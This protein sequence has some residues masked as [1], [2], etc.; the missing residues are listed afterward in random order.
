MAVM[1][2]S[3]KQHAVFAR[4]RIEMKLKLL[5]IRAERS[6]RWFAVKGI[7]YKGT[8]AR[9]PRCR[10]RRRIDEA[11]IITPVAVDQCAA[12]CL[13]EAVRSLTTMWSRCRW[14]RSDVT[15]HRPLPVFRVVRCSSVYYFQTRITVELFHW[16]RAPI[17]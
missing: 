5:D 8:L 1:A 11:D 10:R 4:R 16:T 17:A 12:N 14:S 9:N 7:L 2:C 15:F 13:E 6:L 3:Q